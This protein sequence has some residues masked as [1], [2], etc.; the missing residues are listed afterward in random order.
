MI[1]SYPSQSWRSHETPWRKAPRCCQASASF[2]SI[3]PQSLRAWRGYWRK[4]RAVSLSCFFRRLAGLSSPCGSRA[5]GIQGN[6][7]GL[8]L[9][10]A[11]PHFL[12]DVL[13]NGTLGVTFSQRHVA[14]HGEGAGR[15]ARPNV[16]ANPVG[17]ES[18]RR[19]LAGAEPSGRTGSSR[20][21]A[22]TNNRMTRCARRGS[23][24]KGRQ[25]DH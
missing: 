13:G 22:R 9:R 3:Q 6:G 4:G 17:D 25:S 11:G 18:I 1:I 15:Q 16:L 24:S 20:R 19:R 7:H 5:G 21:S 8:L 2:L 12:A 23:K 10:L 14:L